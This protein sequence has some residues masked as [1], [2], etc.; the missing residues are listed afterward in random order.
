MSRRKR[1]LKKFEKET[2]K[3]MKWAYQRIKGLV[4]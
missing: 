1:K 4:K 3:L 2:D